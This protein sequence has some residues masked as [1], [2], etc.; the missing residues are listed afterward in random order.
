MWL[1]RVTLAITQMMLWGWILPSALA[2]GPLEQAAASLRFVLQ[3]ETSRNNLFLNSG[4]RGDAHCCC[5]CLEGF[6]Y[7]ILNTSQYC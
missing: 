5:T 7:V 4:L 2:V 3:P 1:F 6:K